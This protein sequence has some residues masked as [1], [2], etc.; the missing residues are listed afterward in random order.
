[1]SYEIKYNHFSYLI[2]FKDDLVDHKK[3]PDLVHL[4]NRLAMLG[5]G[6]QFNDDGSLDWP[7]NRIDQEFNEMVHYLLKEYKLLDTLRGFFEFDCTLDEDTVHKVLAKGADED[8]VA[9]LVDDPDPRYFT[10]EED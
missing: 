6:K 7:S 1:M 10:Q 8:M 5:V 9:F 4:A 3:N 2:T